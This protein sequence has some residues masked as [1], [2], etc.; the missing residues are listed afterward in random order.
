MNKIQNVIALFLLCISSTVAA[1]HPS[2][3]ERILSYSKKDIL[4]SI[5][6]A[7]KDDLLPAH[8]E[9]L[10][11]LGRKEEIIALLK[12][13]A[14]SSDIFAKL[15]IRSENVNQLECISALDVL[16]LAY[17]YQV[18][19]LMD[20]VFMYK[21]PYIKTL[22]NQDY[23]EVSQALIITARTLG[24]PADKLVTVVQ[25]KPKPEN[26][27]NTHQS[28]NNNYTRLNHKLAKFFLRVKELDIPLNQVNAV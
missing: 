22:S 10:A 15:K 19:N 25:L 16:L 26:R 17:Q 20:P 6:Y 14:D 21:I 13:N 7:S 28:R 27:E 9:G 24:I 12:Y 2:L 3:V 1:M 8:H 4:S 18:L 23:I 11:L 5:E